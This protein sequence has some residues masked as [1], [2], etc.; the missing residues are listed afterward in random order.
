MKPFFKV[1]KHPNYKTRWM[2]EIY[3][4]PIDLKIGGCDFNKRFS[5]KKKAESWGEWAVR[6]I[7][8]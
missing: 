6:E 4:D 2:C 5:S 8:K 1:S 7:S 3:M